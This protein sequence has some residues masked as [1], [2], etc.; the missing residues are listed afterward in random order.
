MSQVNVLEETE[1]STRYGFNINFTY[2][3]N[4]WWLVLMFMFALTL[5]GLNLTRLQVKEV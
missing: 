5:N 4:D 2:Q 3:D 1:T